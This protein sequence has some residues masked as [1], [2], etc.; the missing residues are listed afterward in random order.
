MEYALVAVGGLCHTA[1]HTTADQQSHETKTLPAGAWDT[2]ESAGSERLDAGGIRRA[3][4]SPHSYEKLVQ[5]T[6]YSEHE[7]NE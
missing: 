7:L 1:C 4:T 6:V 5:M 3:H 2:T